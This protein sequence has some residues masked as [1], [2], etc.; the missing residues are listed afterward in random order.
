MKTIK[1]IGFN[2]FYK[3]QNL[4]IIKFNIYKV[5]KLFDISIIFFFS[6]I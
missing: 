5:K 6:S 2:E 3:L 4:I 1:L